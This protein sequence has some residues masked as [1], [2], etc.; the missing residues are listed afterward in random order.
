MNFCLGPKPQGLSSSLAAILASWSLISGEYKEKSMP[1]G[2]MGD[3][4]YSKSQLSKSGSSQG[5]ITLQ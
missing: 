1:V 2:W 5:P 4:V 3:K